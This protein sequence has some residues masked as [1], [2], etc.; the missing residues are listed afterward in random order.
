MYVIS[1]LI[2]VPQQD[3]HYSQAWSEAFVQFID[4]H[5]TMEELE[6][7]ADEMLHAGA[8]FKELIDA[9]R[10]CPQDDLLSQLVLLQDRGET[11]TEEEIIATC[12]LLLSA[13]HETTVNLIANGYYLLLR[14]PE[15]CEKLEKDE[16]LLANAVEEMLRYEPP[17]LT[18][19]RWVSE[20]I[21]YCG[22]YLKK[23]QFIIIALGGANRD[24]RS[25]P[26]PDRFDIARSPVKHLSFASGAHYCIGAPLARLEG[27]IAIG[28]LAKH[29]RQP[30]L[31]EAP[32]W[33]NSIALRGFESLRIEAEIKL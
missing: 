33:K 6:Q 5:R 26:E 21:E 18:T 27:Q 14:H 19:S 24:P 17:A 32:K 23:G 28:M 31:L 4:F 9:R 7:A 2:G 30:R 15:Q 22:C 11:V 20:D 16:S 1:D 12:V 10:R 8:Y 29:L 25:M 13:G 3:R